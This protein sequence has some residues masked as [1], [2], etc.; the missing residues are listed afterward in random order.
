MI[1]RRT[2]RRRALALGATIHTNARKIAA[3]KF[4]TGMFATALKDDEIVT[5]VEFPMP[6]KAGYAKF[7]NPASLYAMV[8]VFVAQLEDGSVRVAVTGA[9]QACSACP[10]WKRRWR[11][12]FS[13]DALAGIAVRPRASTADMH[14]SAEYRAHLISVMARRAV[15]TASKHITAG[16]RA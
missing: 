3:D 12:C 2:I 8:G 5:A 4:F 14:A 6:K 10:R 1:R 13:A 15:E 7:P 16:S 11:R 9:A